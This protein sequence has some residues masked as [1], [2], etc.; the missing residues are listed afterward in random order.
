MKL[1]KLDET[2]K[3]RE[4]LGGGMKHWASESEDVPQAAGVHPLWART[5]VSLE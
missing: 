1:S 5:F 2:E 4:E 3:G